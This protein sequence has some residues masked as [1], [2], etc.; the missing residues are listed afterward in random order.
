MNSP[1]LI[2]GFVDYD[3]V[4]IQTITNYSTVNNYTYSATVG[5][6]YCVCVLA[7]VGIVSWIMSRIAFYSAE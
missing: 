1:T 7:V 6:I 5:V 4:I 2:D 3:N